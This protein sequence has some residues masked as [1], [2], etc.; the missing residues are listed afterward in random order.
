VSLQQN[1]A[2]PGKRKLVE[3]NAPFEAPPA[4]NSR[5]DNEAGDSRQTKRRRNN[6]QAPPESSEPIGGAE[7]TQT[8]FNSPTQNLGFGLAEP[9]GGW[10]DS[11]SEIDEGSPD[12]QALPGEET[13]NI[14]FDLAEPPGGFASDDE[15]EEPPFST[16]PEDAGIGPHDLPETIP[17]TQYYFARGRSIELGSDNQ[18]DEDEVEGEDTEE[19]EGEEKRLLHPSRKKKGDVIAWSPRQSPQAADTQAVFNAETQALDFDIAQPSG[20]WESEEDEDEILDLDVPMPTSPAATSVKSPN[21]LPL[22]P[23]KHLDLNPLETFLNLMTSPPHSF[24]VEDVEEA[25]R[26]T[27]MNLKLAD[28]VLRNI[29]D[30]RGVPP[31]TKGVWTKR[32]D[33]ALYGRDSKAIE[34]LEKKHGDGAVSDR[35]DFLSKWERS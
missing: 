21:R 14:S 24:T 2:S 1:T 28:R 15:E 3:F 10:N 6:F 16:A 9:I 30:G 4:E 29:Q 35:M 23:Q 17:E 18:I 12:V 20:G 34:A 25:T 27:S 26:L 31:R 13:Q 7:D 5:L 11:E 22:P 19:K 32:D 33:E 8:V